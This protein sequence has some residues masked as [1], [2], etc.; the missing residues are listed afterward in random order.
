MIRLVYLRQGIENSQANKGRL[1]CS[2]ANYHSRLG[3][4]EEA[5]RVYEEACKTVTSAKDFSIIFDSHIKLEE[6]IISAELDFCDDDEDQEELED[7]EENIDAL[8]DRL[9]DLLGRRERA[10]KPS[11]N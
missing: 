11:L 6:T 3:N 7:D 1:W 2:L 10:F 9:E 5:K 8:M 4:F